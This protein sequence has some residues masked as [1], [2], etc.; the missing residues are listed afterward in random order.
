MAARP[1]TSQWLPTVGYFL[2]RGFGREVLS[3]TERGEAIRI[4]RPCIAT[5]AER[6]IHE[7][8]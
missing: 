4:S 1:T 8:S 3:Y 7:K 6:H 2:S 5:Q